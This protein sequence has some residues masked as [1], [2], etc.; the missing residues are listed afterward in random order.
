MSAVATRSAPSSLRPALAFLRLEI[1]RVARNR[2]YLLLT[3]GFP[4]F[5]YLLNTR[6]ESA[7]S[8][9][10]I[11][12]IAW[13]V[14][15]MIGMAVFGSVGAS[16]SVGGQRL[17][18]ERASGWTRQLRITPLSPAAYALTKVAT[19]LIVTLPAL[20]V[21]GLAGVLV[22]GVALAPP[23][24][25]AVIL[26]LWIGSLPFAAL[27]LILGLVLDTDTAQLG[28][29]AAYLVLA[30]VGGLF[31]PAQTM[32]SVLQQIAHALPPFHLADL[33]WRAVAGQPIDPADPAV[34]LGYAVVLFAAVAWLYRRDTSQEHA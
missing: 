34:L 30:F 3:L 25:L 20:V 18:A 17:A 4:L 26:L 7:V 19:A 8:R 24:W 13:P 14:Y 32:P 9:G 28:V 6:I 22:D 16:F 29:T 12:G 21:I 33:G 2:R 11:D 1:L 5:F 31:Q 15:F 27:G 23:T 10:R